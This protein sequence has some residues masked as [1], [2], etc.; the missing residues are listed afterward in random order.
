MT[1][2]KRLPCNGLLRVEAVAE[3]TGMPVAPCDDDDATP[4]GTH[5]RQL[6]HKARLVRHVLPTLQ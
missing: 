3:K 1:L 2:G 6:P 4:R 5:S